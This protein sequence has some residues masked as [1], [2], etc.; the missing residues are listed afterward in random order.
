MTITDPTC[1]LVPPRR[2]S[3]SITDMME[4]KIATHLATRYDTTKTVVR[5]YFKVEN[6]EQWSQVRRL[7]GG[8]VMTAASMLKTYAN[9]RRDATFVRVSNFSLAQAQ[10]LIS[11]T[12]IL[13]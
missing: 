11:F 9:D 8:D 5:M 10:A 13:V 2:D 12:T 6:V 4:D 1:E 3:R 7:G